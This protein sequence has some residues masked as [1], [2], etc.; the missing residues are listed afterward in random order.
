[1]ERVAIIAI[2]LGAMAFDLGLLPGLLGVL[3]EALRNFRPHPSPPRRP[4]HNIR[5]DIRLYGD[6]RLVL[7][8]EVM[9]ILG[10]VAL[11]SS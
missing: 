11:P 7:G 3:M 10:L 4:T 5:T 1:M 2:V 8:G 9:M 6:I